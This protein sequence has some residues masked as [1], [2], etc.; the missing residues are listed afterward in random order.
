[1]HLGIFQ[2]ALCKSRGKGNLA[3]C[4][5]LISEESMVYNS[6]KFCMLSRKRIQLKSFFGIVTWNQI[7][8]GGSLSSR[9]SCLL[10]VSQLLQTVASNEPNNC[11]DKKYTFSFFLMHCFLVNPMKM[12]QIQVKQARKQ[13]ILQMSKQMMLSLWM[14]LHSK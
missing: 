3:F 6:I 9:T 8:E 2:N 5:V 4:L 11:Y 1:M 13:L 12:K 10:E 7:V 14:I